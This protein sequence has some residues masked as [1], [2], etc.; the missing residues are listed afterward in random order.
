MKGR[1]RDG[2]TMGLPD[3][4][5]ARQPDDAKTRRREEIA[6]LSD[7]R[8][9]GEDGKMRKNIILRMPLA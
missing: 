4:K 1:Q 9:A 3:R 2:E 7:Y 5:T 8:T 6:R